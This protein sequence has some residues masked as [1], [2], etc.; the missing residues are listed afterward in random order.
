MAAQWHRVL[1]IVNL[2]YFLLLRIDRNR[3]WVRCAELHILCGSE[4]KLDYCYYFVYGWNAL[5]VCKVRYDTITHILFHY[6]QKSF[7]HSFD[8]QSIFSSSMHW[9]TVP[10]FPCDGF[11][12]Q[13]SKGSL[14]HGSSVPGESWFSIEKKCVWWL[15][16]AVFS[17]HHL[18]G[19]RGEQSTKATIVSLNI[20]S[21][22]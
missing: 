9:K 16:L 20:W 2:L 8:D 10:F 11:R 12:T 4:N 17:N 5:C 1:C 7:V 18:S 3:R 19:D 22:R 6:T 21:I 15:T 13:F 14:R